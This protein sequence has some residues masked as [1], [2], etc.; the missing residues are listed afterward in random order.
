MHRIPSDCGP[1]LV[2]DD[3]AGMRS[4]L[5][6]ILVGA[7]YATVE[8]EEGEAAVAAAATLRP[9]LVLLDV[10]MPG[11]SGHEVCRRVRAGAAGSVPI[12]FVSG[13]RTDALDRATGIELGGDDYL[14]K[15]FAPEELLARVHSLLRRSRV[16]ERIVSPLTAREDEV[17]H[18]LAEG[19]GDAAIARR[20]VISRKTV[21][22]HVGHIYEKLGVRNRA[23]AVAHGYQRGLL[24]PR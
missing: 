13:E 14:V 3:H 23:G 4:L 1:I 17:L 7:G 16:A 18:L 12:L 20:L 8:V 11:I 19:L 15:P 2:V 10:A 21:G 6:R 5:S 9:A 22:A 24:P